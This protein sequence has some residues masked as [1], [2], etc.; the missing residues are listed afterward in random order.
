MN[1][2]EHLV[3]WTFALVG[4]AYLVNLFMKVS[5]VVWAFTFALGLIGTLMPDSLEPATGMGHRGSFHSTLT[6]KWVGLIFLVTFLMGFLFHWSYAVSGFFLGY[7]IHLLA[8][9]TTPAGL[10]Y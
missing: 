2:K 7:F 6:L 4:Y 10:P 5:L 9:S 8:D 1:R 3:I